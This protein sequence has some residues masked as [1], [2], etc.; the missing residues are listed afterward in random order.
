MNQMHVPKDEEIKVGDR[1]RI[2]NP[3]APSFC[4]G[5]FEVTKREPELIEF[6]RVAE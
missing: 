1:F 3:D 4:K 5:L 2:A 6:K